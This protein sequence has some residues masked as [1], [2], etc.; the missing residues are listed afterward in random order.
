MTENAIAKAIADAADRIHTTLGPGL[1]ESV[2]ETVLP[3]VL[4]LP[5]GPSHNTPTGDA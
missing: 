2:Y 5:R 1:L 4:G 3:Y